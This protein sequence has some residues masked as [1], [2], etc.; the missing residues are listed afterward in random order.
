VVS[1]DHREP[2]IPYDLTGA[3]SLLCA[4]LLPDIDA[5]WR[6]KPPTELQRLVRTALTRV[7]VPFLAVAAAL[8]HALAPLFSRTRF[9]NTYRIIARR[10]A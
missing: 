10:T 2:H 1:T 5:P 6:A 9:S 8:D 3:V 7:T 4:R